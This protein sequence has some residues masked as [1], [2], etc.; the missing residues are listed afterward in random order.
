MRFIPILLVLILLTGC[1]FI[2]G[3]ETIVRGSNNFV[4][5][6]GSSSAVAYALSRSATS[7]LTRGINSFP[8]STASG[9]GS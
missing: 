3:G 8:Y 1:D 2:G 5:V 9:S 6:D 4:S 7:S